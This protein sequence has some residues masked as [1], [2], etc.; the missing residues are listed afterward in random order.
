[1]GKKFSEET[2]RKISEALRENSNTKGKHWKLSEEDREKKSMSLKGQHFSLTTEFKKG[3]LRGLRFGSGQKG[4][5]QPHT[6][7]AKAKMRK[8]HI[9]KNLSEETK[10]KI[11][12]SL[13]GTGMSRKTGERS[14][15]LRDEKY[16]RWRN[17]VFKRDD[18]T[19]GDC[20]K[21][22]GVL[23]P[24]HLKGWT[25]YPELRYIIE[26]GITLCKNCH[27]LTRKKKCG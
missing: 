23:E 17:E 3:H 10:K 11:S 13:G 21:R 6:E 18:W 5:N 9:G 16:M 4:H 19:C 8:V 15:H 25:K 24:H 22:G 14:Y 26:N 7:E 20:G 2:R 1:M 12:I 27:I